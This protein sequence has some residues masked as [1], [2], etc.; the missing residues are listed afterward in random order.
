MN[1]IIIIQKD[2]NLVLGLFPSLVD[3]LLILRRHLLQVFVTLQIFLL[4]LLTTVRR[5]LSHLI[6]R[7]HHLLLF[8]LILHLCSILLQLLHLPFETVD[9]FLVDLQLLTVILGLLINYLGDHPLILLEFVV[10][11][12]QQSDEPVVVR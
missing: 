4:Q 6:H 2:S 9:L 12:L 7:L 11:L 1:K 8:L 3:L 10:L 5:D